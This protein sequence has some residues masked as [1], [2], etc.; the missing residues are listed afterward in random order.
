[1]HWFGAG[2]RP[3]SFLSILNFIIYEKI[4]FRNALRGCDGFII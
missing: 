1:M 2:F 4:N 3:G